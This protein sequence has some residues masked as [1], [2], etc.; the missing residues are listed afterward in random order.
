MRLDDNQYILWGGVTN[1]INGNNASNLLSFYTNAVERFRIDGSGNVGI[2][3]PTPAEKLTVSGNISASGNVLFY[4]S[5]GRN[6]DLIHTPANDGTNPVLRIGESIPGDTALSGFSG[7]FVSYDEST[8]VFG[9]SSLF[10]PEKGVPAI[11]IERFGNVGIGT[12]SPV[13]KLEVNGSMR[14][15]RGNDMQFT[16]GLKWSG[17]GSTEA[18]SYMSGIAN[19]TEQIRIDTNGVKISDSKTLTLG[20]GTNVALDT[21]TGSKIGTATTQ[22]LSFYNSTPIVQPSSASQAAVVAAAVVTTTPTLGAYGYTLAQAT[23]II[24]LVNEIRPLVNELRSA[25]VT[26]GLIKGSA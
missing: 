15:G 26:L 2:G 1:G 5:T 21:I 6:L 9:I 18:N 23:S 17:T 3:A 7:A 13:T 19:S 22:K 14:V 11:A 20:A 10:L 12:T 25:L 8:N 4:S 16:S 24:T